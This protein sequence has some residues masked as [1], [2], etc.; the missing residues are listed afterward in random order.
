LEGRLYAVREQ[1]GWNWSAALESSMDSVYRFE[2]RNG[3]GTGAILLLEPVLSWGQVCVLRDAL[4]ARRSEGLGKREVLEVIRRTSFRY[5]FGSLLHE[6][7]RFGEWS[8]FGAEPAGEAR[9]ESELYNRFIR[10]LR[11]RSLLPEELFSMLEHEGLEGMKPRWKH[12]VQLGILRGDLRVDKGMDDAQEPDEL[13]KRV[14]RNLQG[15]GGPRLH[16]RRCGSERLRY[17]TCSYCQGECPYC[18][19]CLGMGRVRFCSPL[20][21]GTEEGRIQQAGTGQENLSEYIDPWGLSDAQ[22]TAVIEGMSKVDEAEGVPASVRRLLVWAV[23]GAGKTEM[24]F[25]FIAREL[26]RGGRVLIASPR[27]DVV[28][29]L[30]PR[31]AKAF[32]GVSIVTLHGSSEQ[33]WE[34]GRI[35]L[36]TAHQLLRYEQAFDLV[37]IDEV[38]AFPYHNN[39][40]L[41]YAASKVCKPGGTFVFLTATPPKELQRSL[42]NGRIPHVKV[43]ARYH[44]HP[45]PVP[46][47]VLVKPLSYI[48][49]RS[50]LPSAVRTRFEHSLHRGAQLFVFVPY[51]KQVEPMVKL[52]R[53]HFSGVNIQGTSSQD[54]DRGEKVLQFRDRRIRILVTTTILERGVTVPKSDVF[55]LGAD[56]G[57]FD[58]GALVQ[59]AGRAGRSK[60]DP[61]G[62]VYFVSA[63]RTKAQAGAIRQIRSMNRIARN[64]GYLI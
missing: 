37:V 48:V 21:G 13:L 64:E 44:R 9:I 55:I 6:R 49:A 19:E 56:S 23:T 26:A 20:I 22:R 42:R 38:D 45:L 7:V 8:G 50:A 3:A 30:Q 35:T 59:M 33:R 57:M 28:L 24:L 4:K 52:L 25:P 34:V 2:K 17:T 32:E 12:Y 60:D 63:E 47:N 43:P 39:P 18:E 51:I 58:E 54:P 16:C 46:E 11:G 1:N 5:G 36:S 62:K 29:E 10:G 61:A 15:S 41:Q 53:K 27:R 40:M 31:L 14:F